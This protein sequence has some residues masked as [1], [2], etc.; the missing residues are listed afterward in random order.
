MLSKSMKIKYEGLE[1]NLDALRDLNCEY[2]FSAGEI[3][4]S[5]EMGLVFMGYYEAETSYWGV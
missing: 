5:E 1:F 3:L 4:D 2:I